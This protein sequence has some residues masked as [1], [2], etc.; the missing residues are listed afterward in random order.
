MQSERLDY[1][2][3]VSGDGDFIQV[4]RALQNK[5]CRVEV[6]HS[7]M[8]RKNCATKP[9]FFTPGYLVPELLPII[10]NIEAGKERKVC[11]RD[12]LFFS[13]G[14]KLWIYAFFERN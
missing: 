1:V 8:W 12:L 13:C 6:W 7:K 2:L 10:S 9:T 14:K 5:G 11:E 4:V 3:L